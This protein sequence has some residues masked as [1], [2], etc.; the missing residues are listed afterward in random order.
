MLQKKLNPCKGCRGKDPEGN[1]E[2]GNDRHGRHSA[3]QREKRLEYMKHEKSSQKKIRI[4]PQFF[5]VEKIY[6]QFAISHAI[7]SKTI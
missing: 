1:D 3:D 4:Y 7:L 6:T 2:R 5:K